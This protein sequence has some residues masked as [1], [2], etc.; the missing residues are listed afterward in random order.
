MTTVVVDLAK[1]IYL[2]IARARECH[3]NS[4][5]RSGDAHA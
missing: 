2:L 5:F 4:L 1:L 3:E